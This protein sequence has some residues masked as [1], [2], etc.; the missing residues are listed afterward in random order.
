[1]YDSN[2]HDVM[3]VMVSVFLYAAAVSVVIIAVS[4][5]MRNLNYTADRVDEKQSINTA[6]NTVIDYRMEESDKDMLTKSQVLDTV[7]AV[8]D[9]DITK[10]TIDG[11]LVSAED[12]KQ[13]KEG[14]ERSVKDIRDMLSHSSY[15]RHNIY[16]TED[17]VDRLDTIAFRGV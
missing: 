9:P 16:D 11:A 8:A 5:Y 2:I 17:G 1:M 3:E 6:Q 12:I 10:V 7:I 14:D 13:A 4:L 15:E